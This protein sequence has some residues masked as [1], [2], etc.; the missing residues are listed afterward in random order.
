MKETNLMSKVCGICKTEKELT[1]FSKKKNGK[2][3]LDS[4][5]KMCKNIYNKQYIIVN[6]E[7]LKKYHYNYYRNN[8]EKV[9]A[10][11]N[12]IR[13]RRQ[14]I[15][16]SFKLRNNVRNAVGKAIIASYSKKSGNSILKPFLIL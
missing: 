4:T 10:K 9:K 1:C 12:K 14:L 2:L 3:G 11:N 8:K 7:E 5:C 15:D 13:K 6:K 16:P